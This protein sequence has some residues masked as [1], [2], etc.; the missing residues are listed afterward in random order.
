MASALNSN[1]VRAAVSAATQKPLA[2][3]LGGKRITRLTV[4]GGNLVLVLQATTPATIRP[5]AGNIT[6]VQLVPKSTLPAPPPPKK[7]STAITSVTAV[8]KAS[9]KNVTAASSSG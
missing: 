9:E 8:L 4:Y 5:I 1:L 6:L 3:L 2:T 7:V